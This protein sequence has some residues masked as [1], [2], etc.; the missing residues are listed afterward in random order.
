MSEWREYTL[1]DLCTEIS[2][3][4]TESAK[5]E[6]VG[7]KFLR[8]TDIA[9]G[10]LDWSMVPYC[11][12]IESDY[13]KYKLS[14]GDIV[15]ARTG[16]TTGANYTMKES[17][18]NDVVFA[19]YLIRYKINPQIAYPYY[20]GHL[21]RSSNWSDYVDSIAGGSAQPGANAKQLGSFEILLPSI[22]TQKSIAS[23]LSSLDDKIDLLHRQ[24]ATLEKMAETLFRKWFVEEAKEEWEIVKVGD[25]VK[26]NVASIAK[27]YPYDIIKYLDTSSLNEGSIDSTQ[28][29][30][31]FEAPSRAKR[32]V[33]HNDVL[34]STVRPNQKHYGIVKNPI[35]N[36]VVSTGFC[37]ITCEKIDPHFIY[38]LLTTQEM[39]EYLHSIAEGSTS[40]YPSLKPSDI[41][42]IEFQLPPNDLL[43]DFANLCNHSW[44]KIS[45]NQLQIQTLVR[46]R[47]TLLPKLMCGEVQVT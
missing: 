33:K 13:R 43:S 21:L 4:Y 26:T 8:I 39:T 45:K 22:E 6:K 19:S 5:Q 14:P 12:I 20:I 44:D 27:N 35:E 28:I 31:L 1:T 38:I 16:A 30:K 10:R 18:P 15:I 11:P 42:A 37:V 29:L 32:L 3:G 7:P 47:D 25:F 36:L 17:D 2:Y 9:S 23:I 34:I 40:T 24:N 41:E 46:L